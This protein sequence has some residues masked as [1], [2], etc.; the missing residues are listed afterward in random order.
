MKT[1]R[2]IV[3]PQSPN[4]EASRTA[5]ETAARIVREGGLVAFPTETVYGLGANALDSESV[6]KIFEAKERP[7]WDPLIVH[8]SDREM[9]SRVLSSGASTLTSSATAII[10]AFWPGPLTLLLLKA[11]DIPEI[12][13]AARPLVGV[14]IPSHPVARA[15][16][17]TAG[18]P[19]AAPSANRFGRISPT[20]A[21][22][23]LEDLD[24]RIDAVLDAGEATHGLESTVVDAS[25]EPVVLYRPGVISIEKL[26]E[27]C[28]SAVE[29][30]SEAPGG[31]SDEAEPASMP[32]PGL[33]IRHSPGPVSR[34]RLIARS[35]HPPLR[36]ARPPHPDWR[37]SRGPTRRAPTGSET[38]CVRAAIDRHYA[39]TRISA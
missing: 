12:V 1:L 24:G 26:R 28:G 16:I 21:S 7:S 31:S 18:V 25:Q 20:Q 14:R 19:I 4:T 32:S 13:T 38:S 2:L 6:K 8:V 10:S 9:L 3:D 22:H 33:G 37:H 36:P 35:R 29:W 15:L 27:A 23:V 39:S 17:A 34:R 30:K 11:D 5:I